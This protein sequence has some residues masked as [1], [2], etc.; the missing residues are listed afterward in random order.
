MQLFCLVNVIIADYLIIYFICNFKIRL[1]KSSDR[2]NKQQ[3]KNNI[4]FCCY[5]INKDFHFITHLDVLELLYLEPMF[6][7]FIT[8]S[9]LESLGKR[10]VAVF[11]LDKDKS[12]SIHSFLNFNPKE[13]LIFSLLTI[14][15]LTPILPDQF[16]V[17][18]EF[19]SSVNSFKF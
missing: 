2:Y 19:K 17:K 18:L 5:A 16:F 10:L 15:L 9:I 8:K 1:A 14:S 12:I 4:D 13:A 6:P 7:K 3:D 11:L